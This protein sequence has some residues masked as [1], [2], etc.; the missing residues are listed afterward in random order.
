MNKRHKATSS[1]TARS[2]RAAHPQG[3]PRGRS[4]STAEPPST[5]LTLTAECLVQDAGALKSGLARLLTE[6]QPV[7]LDATA[8]QRVDTAGLQL[9]T[10]FV[11]ERALRGLEVEWNGTAPALTNAA[12]L[13][14]LTSLLKLPA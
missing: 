8:V 6:S 9:I 4:K 13:L 11:Q 5:S 10:A 14:G 7:T 12:Q 1:G 3:T 2:A